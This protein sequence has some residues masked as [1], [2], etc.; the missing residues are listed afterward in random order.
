[1]VK[2]A[3]RIVSSFGVPTDAAHAAMAGIWRMWRGRRPLSKLRVVTR[4]R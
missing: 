3:G 4:I 1:M 2:P